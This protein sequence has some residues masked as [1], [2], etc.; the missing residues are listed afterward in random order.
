MYN[1]IEASLISLY[2]HS[3]NLKTQHK[4]FVNALC[5]CLWTSTATVR[6]IEYIQ[7]CRKNGEMNLK[8]IFISTKT[9]QFENTA[10]QTLGITKHFDK[11]CLKDIEKAFNIFD[12]NKDGLLSVMV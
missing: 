9:R 5:I 12:I 1:Q 2:L 3:L 11:M 4:I 8:M 7:G 6:W 10:I